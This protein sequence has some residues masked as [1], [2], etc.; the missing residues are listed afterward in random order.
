MPEESAHEQEPVS[1]VQ[2]RGVT[3]RERIEA[4]LRFGISI[5]VVLERDLEWMVGSCP[6]PAAARQ[7]VSMMR[8][9][10]KG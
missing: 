7:H 9:Y 10:R 5:H 1:T 6:S 3:E 8:R 4:I 2:G